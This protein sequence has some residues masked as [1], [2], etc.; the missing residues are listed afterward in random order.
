[1]QVSYLEGFGYPLGLPFELPGQHWSPTSGWEI[2]EALSNA[3]REML[4]E[5]LA[6]A[7]EG[8]VGVI[9]D[10]STAVDNKQYLAIAIVW[11]RD[12]VKM[13]RF[14]ALRRVAPATVR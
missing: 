12:A 6:Q 3:E 10:D 8:Y 9:A 14:L 13:T 1:L 11:C 7:D 5:S 2:F 4:K